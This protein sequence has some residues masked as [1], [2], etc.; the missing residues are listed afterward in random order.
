MN[1]QKMTNAAPAEFVREDRYI[2][3][4]RSDLAKVPVNYRKALI[5]PL[6]HLQAHLPR[7]ECL[8]IESDWPEYPVAWQMIEARMTGAT[9]VNQQLTASQC[10]WKRDWETGAYQLG[11]CDQAWHFTDG[12]AEENGALFCHRCAGKIMV[13]E[14][15]LRAY[16][17]GDNDIVAAYDPAGAIQ[18]LVDF[19]GYGQDFDE[20][21]VEP[22]S[23]KMLDATEALD[24]DE[25]RTVRL[26]KTLRQELEELTEPAYL[27]GWE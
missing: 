23:D 24:Q 25:G 8:V 1:E 5:E 21:D 13:E 2:V 22:V 27:H 26:E 14:Q 19:A 20:S 11:C 10:I 4:K 18:V 6:G 9:A 12:T 3:I 15:V 17:V 16:Q 7:R